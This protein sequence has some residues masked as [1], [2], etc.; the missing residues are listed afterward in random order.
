MSTT[1]K[2]LDDWVGLEDF[3]D[4]VKRHPRTV[5]RWTQ[6]PDGLPYAMLGNMKIIHIPTAREWLFGR[7]HQ[8]NRRRTSDRAA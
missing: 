4:Q 8:P 1:P 3:A 5:G 2:L 7:M 6:Q